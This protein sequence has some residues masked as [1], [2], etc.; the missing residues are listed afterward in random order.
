MSG[1]YYTLISLSVIGLTV[2]LS[3]MGNR[4]LA[5][6]SAKGDRRAKWYFIAAFLFA[7][8]GAVFAAVAT[9]GVEQVVV[10]LGAWIAGATVG[11]ILMGRVMHRR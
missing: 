5:E 11:V 8:I 10:F 2:L 3:Y 4:R 6:F 9:R 7:V 1:W